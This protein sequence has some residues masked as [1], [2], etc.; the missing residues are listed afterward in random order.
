MQKMMLRKIFLAV[1]EQLLL[2]LCALVVPVVCLIDYNSKLEFSLT[3]I[4]QEISLLFPIVV[5]AYAARRYLHYRGFYLL[6]SAFFGCMLI[7]EWDAFFDYVV[8]GFWVFPAVILAIIAVT[9]TILFYREQVLPAMFDFIRCRSFHCICFGLVTVLVFSRIF[10]SGSLLWKDIL[11]PAY[12]SS[13]KS[14]LQ[15]G[16]ELFG[17]IFILYGSIL[18]LRESSL[19]FKDKALSA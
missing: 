4:L 18:F 17:Y 9:S 12:S 10:G 2:T 16:L 7:R 1:G 11:G 15:E 8:H 19:R 5:F 13:F 6:V 3:E 14:V